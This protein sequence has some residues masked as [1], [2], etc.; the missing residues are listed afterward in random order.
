MKLISLNTWCGKIYEPLKK[1][2]EDNANETDIFCFQEIRNGKYLDR[3]EAEDEVEDLFEKIENILPNFKGYFTE[4]TPGLGL[5]TYIKNT[6]EVEKF[7]SSTVLS[8]EE[9]E[10]IEKFENRTT[11]PRV[12]QV[13]TL[14]NK[15]SILNFHGIY[16][17]YKKDT[18]ERELQ[19]KRIQEIL[20]KLD[21]PKIL[22]GDFN[23][24]PDTNAV[25]ELEKLMRNLIKENNINATRSDLY[26]E[27]EIMPFADYAFVSKDINIK[28][29]RVLQD[30]VSD[31]LPLFLEIK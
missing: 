28:D 7:Y 12:I 29:F 30:E 23:L 4:M 18:K 11:K 10:D 6:L 8:S 20:I 31:H 16:G 25:A 9:L 19:T 3:W 17:G 14:K 24:N 22:I 2:I 5:A 21:E 1:F 13:I 27:K 15:L 26:E